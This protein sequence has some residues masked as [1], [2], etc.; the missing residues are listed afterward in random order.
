MKKIQDKKRFTK[1]IV[2]IIAA[3]A[4]CCSVVFTAGYAINHSSQQS[5]QSQS[6]SGEMQTPLSGESGQ[7]DSNSQSGSGSSTPQA[8]PD[9][10]QSSSDSNS[11]SNQP[12]Q[13]SGN[14]SSDSNQQ[15]GAP[16]GS[17]GEN[18]NQ[19][20]SSNNSSDSNQ[21]SSNSNQNNSSNQDNSNS[22]AGQQMQGG[23]SQPP[24]MPDS[25]SQS[26]SK[27]SVDKAYYI[28]FAIEGALLC[29]VIIYLIMSRFNKKSFK[30]T[31]KNS[32][33]IIIFVLALI[34]ATSAITVGSG[35][36]VNKLQSNSRSSQSMQTQNQEQS[37]EASGATEIT[38]GEKTLT[39]QYTSTTADE[40]AILV[41]GGARATID[42]ATV[43]KSSGDSSN[44]E[45]SEFYG[46]NSGILVQKSSTATIKNATIS[47][48]AKGS[49]AVFSTGE[50]SK[51]YISDSKITTTGES[52]S[53]GLDATY[54]GYIEADNVT[55][56]TQGGS[57][58]ALATDRGEGTVIA[59]KSNLT[60]NGSG[61]PV[62]YS[63]GDI[64]ITNTKGT[65]NGSQMTVIEGK[66][67]A[68]V[69]NSTLTASG[70]GNRNDVDQCGVMIYQSMSG[71]ASEGT[72]TFTAENSSLSINSNSDYY[73][74]APMFFVTNTDAV[75]NLTNTKLSYGSNTLL[76]VKGTDEWGT[77]GSNGGN[78]TLNATNQELSGNITADKISTVTI[79]L[80]SSTYKGAINSDNTAK[81]VSL[82]LDKSSKITLTG[83]TYV[84][85]LSDEDSTYSN[86]NFNGYKLYV[87]SKAIN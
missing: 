33:K 24:E 51:I 57:C 68:T 13:G 85:S 76:S 2:M 5:G 29:A 7:S 32:D 66:N 49:N 17:Q 74:T 69:K 64:S 25:N 59:K 82:T 19:N 80:K 84:S 16:S 55:V 15:G 44:T 73:K 71:D 21:D 3:I 67:S 38:S 62:I 28:L 42:G 72:G 83:D 46:V 20:D 23:N 12:P 58:A 79:S 47:T 37:V 81:T 14:S 10:A 48:S 78:V 36:T 40:S 56:S 39:S 45:N 41:S 18:S 77:S 8:P 30:Q 4:L 6:Q 9:N 54:G 60:T 50:D 70:K 63:T 34:I 26:Q 11:S 31:F 1:N 87:N 22:G 65:A 52:S 75:I 53:R 35:A 27:T 61:S 86:I 43:T